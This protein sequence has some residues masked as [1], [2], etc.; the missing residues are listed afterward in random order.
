VLREL[1]GWLHHRVVAA[2]AVSAER[3][4]LLL[5]DHITV[6]WGGANAASAKAEEVAVL[7]R[8]KATYYDVSDPQSAMTG[9]PAGG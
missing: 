1:P 9:W 7:L 3:V 8:T 2:K 5:R 4:V 6:V